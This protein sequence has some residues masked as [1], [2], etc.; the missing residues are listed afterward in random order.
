VDNLGLDEMD[1]RILRL[2]IEKYNGGPVGVGTIAVAVGETSEAIEEV[3]EPYLILK[4]FIKRT[5]RGRE[6]TEMA[7]RHFGYDFPTPVKS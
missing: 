3:Y 1:K 2:I 6:V 5:Q 4:G 7:Y